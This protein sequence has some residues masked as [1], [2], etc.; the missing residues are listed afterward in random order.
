M[1]LP[2]KMRENLYPPGF[3]PAAGTKR[4]LVLYLITAPSCFSLQSPPGAQELRPGA[5]PTTAH[6]PHPISAPGS[7]SRCPSPVRLL[8]ACGRSDPSLGSVLHLWAWR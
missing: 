2:G 8:S 1:G 6:S 5:E 7:R 4:A 3:F